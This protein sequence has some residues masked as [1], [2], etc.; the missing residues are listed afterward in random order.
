MRPTLFAHKQRGAALLIVLALVLTLGLMGLYM[1]SSSRTQ[2]QL[3]GNVQYAEQAFNQ[4]ESSVARAEA[5]L[6]ANPRDPAFD[7]YS[8][9]T[10][11]HLYPLDGL[12]TQ[13]RDPK[14][15]AWSNSNSIV[16]DQG[17]YLIEQIGAGVTLP[18]TSI[19]LDVP[20]NSACEKVNIYQLH[21][22]SGSVKGTTR[23]VNVTYATPACN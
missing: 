1:Y 15:M 10:T 12:T 11:P 4:V 17:R 16:A 9:A 14:N 5:W 19:D 6:A 21:A 20:D 3:V 8:S 23:M 2:Y 22:T 7:S 13:S 18:G